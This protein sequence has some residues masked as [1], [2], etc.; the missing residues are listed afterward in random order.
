M[1]IYSQFHDYM[2]LLA[3]KRQTQGEASKASISNQEKRQV[4][5]RKTWKIQNNGKENQEKIM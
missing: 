4:G 3:T 5:T 1:F 2:Y